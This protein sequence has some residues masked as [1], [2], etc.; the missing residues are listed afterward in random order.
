MP[1]RLQQQQASSLLKQLYAYLD[2][3]DFRLLTCVVEQLDTK[4]GTVDAPALY[5]RLYPFRQLA[6][7]ER[8]LAEL[9]ARFNTGAAL[10]QA[11]IV[12][13]LSA[14]RQLWFEGS[15]APSQTL[16]QGPVVSDQ[17][18]Q[19][20]HE[21]RLL[22][23]EQEG[24]LP[25][26]RWF[27]SYARKDE[28]LKSA[29]LEQLEECLSI[30]PRYHFSLWQDQ[31][32]LPGQDWDFSI[33]D[34][35]HHAHLGVLLLSTSFFASQYIRSVELPFLMQTPEQ[36][37]S[38]KRIIPIA[39]R[40]LDPRIINMDGLDQRL[41]FSDNANQAF[42]EVPAVD[43]DAWVQ[44][45]VLEIHHVLDRYATVAATKPPVLTQEQAWIPA[46]SDIPFMSRSKVS[47]VART[48]EPLGEET[49][50]RWPEQ[51]PQPSPEA[52]SPTHLFIPPQGKPEPALTLNPPQP[53]SH[54]VQA[55]SSV[56]ALDYMLDWLGDNRAP[57]RFA[58]L[59]D[60]GLG[61]T[62]TCE[63]F[64]H[65]IEQRRLAGFDDLPRP[66]FL[67][68]QHLSGISTRFSVPSIHEILDECAARARTQHQTHLDARGLIRASTIHSLVFI[69]DGLDEVLVHLPDADGQHFMRELLR[70]CP[71]PEEQLTGPKT[72]LLISCRTHYFRSLR[73][74]NSWLLSQHRSM[75]G[76]R[77]FRALVL[78]PFNDHQVES[79]LRQALPGPALESALSTIANTHNLT[80]LA[81]R[82]FNLSLLAER[83]P[84]MATVEVSPHSINS[85]ALVYRRLVEAWLDR[86][87]GKHH[88]AE[89]HKRLL[90]ADLAAH[91]WRCSQKTIATQELE[92]FLNTWLD[93]RA[94]RSRYAHVPLAKLLEDVRTSTFLV[95]VDRGD[96][97]SHFRFAHSS[98][99]EF[100]I[101]EHLLA[102]LENDQRESW[103]LRNISAE[104]LDFLGELLLLPQHEK[105]IES[106]AQWRF[107]YM[108]DASELLLRYALLAAEKGWRIP[109]L[110]KIDMRKA[111]LRGWRFV[112]NDHGL[113]LSGADFRGALLDGTQWRGV[114]LDQCLFDR[115]SLTQA[116]WQDVV[117]DG[118]CFCNVNAQGAYFRNCSWAQSSWNGANLHR[119]VL[120]QSQLPGDVQL[121]AGCTPFI[122]PDPEHYKKSH[123]QWFVSL[124]HSQGVSACC[125]SPDGKRAI[126]ASED[127]TL[128]LWDV[129]AGECL[130]TWSGHRRPVNACGFSP[131]GNIAISASGDHTLRF[132]STTTGEGIYTLNAHTHRVLSCT[133]SP[134]GK[135]VASSSWNVIA[136][137]QAH[138]YGRVSEWEAHHGPIRAVRFFPDGKRL[139]SVGD[140]GL[141][142]F[143]DV[144]TQTLLAE[145][146]GHDGTIYD[147][148]VSSSGRFVVSAG[149]EHNLRLW[150][151]ENGQCLATLPGHTRAVHACSISPD[152]SLI[153]SASADD[154][155]K[156]WDAK[157]FSCLQT[158]Q[159]H[160]SW[161]RSCDF[162]PDGK[163]TLSASFDGDL[164]LWSQH[165]QTA[166]ATW[167]G[168]NQPSAACATTAT[169]TFFVSA[170]DDCR[171][172]VWNAAKGTCI[173]TFAGHEATIVKCRISPNGRVVASIADD[174]TLRLWS[175]ESLDPQRCLAVCIGHTSTINDCSFSPDNRT[176]A[177]VS[178]DQTVRLWDAL[179]GSC[180]SEWKGSDAPIAACAFSPDGR[181]LLYG[182]DEQSLKLWDLASDSLTDTW[183]GHD[184]PVVCCNFSQDGTHV[185]SSGDDQVLK[186]WDVAT[187]SHLHTL[188]G[189]QAPVACC[190]FSPDGRKVLSGSFD[191]TLRLWDIDQGATL[192]IW[193]EHQA[194][195]AS[196]DWSRDGKH[197]ISA[198]TDG[199]LIHRDPET[200]H[201]KRYYQTKLGEYAVWDAGSSQDLI[202]A[203]ANAWRWLRWRP[204]TTCDE[205]ELWPAEAFEVLP[206]LA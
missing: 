16:R 56:D 93:E 13:C 15:P 75:L 199:L 147:C 64:V 151:P 194:I 108:K 87:D 40:R 197:I 187:G 37:V 150:S 200:G 153:A 97:D 51:R 144:A 34:A 19:P 62:V 158:W 79:Y 73:S 67:S 162:S 110:T 157:T 18:G 188:E 137:W 204:T 113:N 184:A 33:K 191:T 36:S 54:L 3:V 154:T 103:C 38:G 10:A 148:A 168:Q 156:L 77:D 8:E 121:Q 98:F 206:K 39:L 91:M 132:W 177:T 9:V 163:R 143:W 125:F 20:I 202:E 126:S 52:L 109:H 74:Q 164:R 128:K 50:R 176:L 30:S 24:G 186:V 141:I 195:I 129:A 190:I 134:D 145:G 32:T 185:V 171:L 142:K 47:T 136:L 88:L 114:L 146:R 198:S 165:S 189:H 111:D 57:P 122:V 116:E 89:R 193:D 127:R 49:A 182:G 1:K 120:V 90:M 95:R 173:A 78:Q 81:R 7:A 21:P 174:H 65:E 166:V 123:G 2:S 45:L 53:P 117:A 135:L 69:L 59:G 23:E 172:R 118:T 131:D 101:A 66:V 139:V 104:T 160:R 41:I 60:Y 105:H 102:A 14:E 175:L 106:L 44:A 181:H 70:L 155:L 22:L 201:I 96:N 161:A 169:A 124:G 5:L 25:V 6:D 58:L 27:L 159:G 119:T 28:E 31:N 140:D 167:H 17:R 196:C 72:R 115:S 183:I 205:A 26:V 99:Q 149:N 68:L 42:S 178:N 63:R 203:S 80:E 180:I 71:S 152:E 82:P 11:P 4:G 48:I 192:S 43:R 84:E 85:A 130:R 55:S 83:L 86:D 61:K 100:F 107:H 29:L 12:L 170:S 112:A 46:P 92:D 35:L 76:H 94:I 179:T 133:F 138:D